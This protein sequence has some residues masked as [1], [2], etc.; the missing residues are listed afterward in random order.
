MT[1]HSTKPEVTGTRTGYVIRFTCPV[2]TAENLIVNKTPRDH[3]KETRDASCTRCR[4]R[5]TI[6]T[7]NG[8]AKKA[9][10]ASVLP[11]ISPVL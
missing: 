8:P 11:I 5:S 9:S 10:P 7:P 4:K 6:L 3:F 2:C 1:R